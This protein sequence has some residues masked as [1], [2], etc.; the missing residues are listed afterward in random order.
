MSIPDARPILAKLSLEKQDIE[1]GVE[2]FAHIRKM[3]E[4]ANEKSHFGGIGRDL[5]FSWPPI[6]NHVGF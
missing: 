5:S 3:I 4:N 6:L 2:W 1:N